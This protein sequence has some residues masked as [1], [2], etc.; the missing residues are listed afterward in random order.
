MQDGVQIISK[1]VMKPSPHTFKNLKLSY[2][3]RSLPSIY[4]PFIFFY[5][6]DEP[7]G[8]NTSN[9]I[10]I[11]QILKHSLL[12][13]LPSF[14]PLAGKLKHGMYVDCSDS[15][16]GF[17]FVEA[18][19][20]SEL[21][22]A[23]QGS[24]VT[25][26]KLLLPS[27]CTDFDHAGW[28]LLVVQVTFFDCGGLAIAISVSHKIADFASAMSFVAAWAATC[29][30]EK[31]E[32]PPSILGTYPYFRPLSWVPFSPLMKYYKPSDEYVTERF[33]FDKKKIDILRQATTASPES[34]TKDPSRV[35]LVSAFIWKHFI[36]ARSKKNK[37]FAAQMAVSL[38]QRTD[39][40]G[41]LENVF[42]N[43]FMSSLAFGDPSRELHHLVSRLREAIRK[44]RDGYITKMM[45]REC[46]LKEL[47]M[48][49]VLMVTGQME[50]CYFTS[51]RGFSAYKVDYG[52]G[53]PC[54]FATPSLAIKNMVVLVNSGGDDIEA[55]V[56]ML[57]EVVQAVGA[58]IKLISLNVN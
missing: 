53:Q 41:I 12:A 17:E 36:A 24:T 8:L 30:G 37:I 9:H 2:I 27:Y 34:A 6:A 56:T 35:E 50:W 40:P 31:T 43:C 39:P 11:S 26:M 46:Y 3:D 49:A 7:T 54:R 33:I 16:S 5:N 52:W 55:I 21:E 18:K 13:T 45:S 58:Q 38:R 4:I 25:D 20:H 23:L 14:Y 32:I 22:T 47:A 51:W 48:L 29:R 19:V 44:V 42:G 10:Q 15:A 57:P 1:E 28:P